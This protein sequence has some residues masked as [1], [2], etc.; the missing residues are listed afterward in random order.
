MRSA[1]CSLR[2][3][4]PRR[5]AW[6]G[7]TILPSGKTDPSCQQSTPSIGR[8]AMSSV[9]LEGKTIGGLAPDETEPRSV[10]S[11]SGAFMMLRRDVWNELEGFDETFF[12]YG[13]ELDLCHRIRKSGRKLIMTPRSKI[14]HLVGSGSAVNPR[15]SVSIA[16]AKMHFLRKHR[17]G[18]YASL[19]GCFLWLAAVNRCL[20]GHLGKLA[21]RG[22]RYQDMAVAFQAMALHPSRW[23]TGYPKKDS[24]NP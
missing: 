9:G 6:G 13:E 18:L 2:L 11:L 12:M 24:S 5:R 15:R 17:G 20:A 10:E 3:I 21:G 19:C 23:W 7:V 4:I 14:V 16:K 22:K 8:I 1:N